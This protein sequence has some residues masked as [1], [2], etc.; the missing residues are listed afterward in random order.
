VGV[1][2]R[3]LESSKQVWSADEGYPG[4][5]LYREFYRDLGYD[6]DYEDVESYLH[7]DKVRRHLGIKYHRVTG[8]VELHE[9]QLYDRHAAVSKAREHGG[10]FVFCR[11]HQLRFL[12]SHIDEPPIVVAPYDAELFGHWWYEGPEFLENVFRTAWHARDDFICATLGGYYAAHPPTQT[13]T[14][15]SSSWG[16]KGY[17]EVWLNGANDWIYR[18]LHKAE[19]RMIE[20]AARYAERPPEP[21]VERALNQA[22]RELLLAQSSDWAFLMTVGTAVP[23]AEKRTR[24]HLH[25]FTRLYHMIGCGSIDEAY[26]DSLRELNPAFPD[27][28]YKAY[29]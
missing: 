8:R 22:V 18:H 25:R 21:H 10:H 20:M 11:Q 19:E 28:S 13:A 23:Y 4:D 17:F 2:A 9:K 15:S 12:R 3:D 29:L 6:A 24:N 26:V 7:A 16:D 14:P 1:F 5:G 27:V